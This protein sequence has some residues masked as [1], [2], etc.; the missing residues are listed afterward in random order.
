M[1]ALIKRR[2]DFTLEEF[3]AYY[4]QKHAPLAARTIPPDV[5][6][7]IRHYGQNHALRL[8]RGKTDPPYDCVTEFRFEDLAGLERWRAWYSGEGGKVLRED[9]EKF[10]DTGG[11]VIIVTDERRASIHRAC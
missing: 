3:C 9:E 10:M 5:A 11:R 2:P 1:I 6:E 4:E 8:G 7:A